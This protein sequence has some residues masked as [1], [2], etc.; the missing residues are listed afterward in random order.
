MN[1][2]IPPVNVAAY[3]ALIITL[4]TFGLAVAALACALCALGIGGGGA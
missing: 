2:F 1:P 4:V 3:S